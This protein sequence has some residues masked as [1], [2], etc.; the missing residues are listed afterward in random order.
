MIHDKINNYKGHYVKDQT[1]TQEWEYKNWNSS[2]SMIKHLRLG[3][4]QLFNI[5][6]RYTKM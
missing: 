6:F 4:V 5:S 2:I 1:P 3:C